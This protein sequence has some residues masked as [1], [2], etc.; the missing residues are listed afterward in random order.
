MKRLYRV[1]PSPVKFH[2]AS[3]ILSAEEEKDGQQR[4]SI[5]AYFWT[6]LGD[7]SKPLFQTMSLTKTNRSGTF[8]PLVMLL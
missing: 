7:N 1:F 5:P 8:V 2:K 4:S 3:S 6:S